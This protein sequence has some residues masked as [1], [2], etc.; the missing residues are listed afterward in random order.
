MP[1]GSSNTFPCLSLVS[2]FVSLYKLLAF[3]GAV[4]FSFFLTRTASVPT[5]AVVQSVLVPKLCTL[6]LC[7]LCTDMLCTVICFF[8][9][10]CLIFSL[11][12]APTCGSTITFLSVIYHAVDHNLVTS[13]LLYCIFWQ[14]FEPDTLCCYC[15]YDKRMVCFP[16]TYNLNES[17]L[18]LFQSSGMFLLLQS[19]LFSEFYVA[20]YCVL[21]FWHIFSIKG[22]IL[23]CLSSAWTENNVHCDIC[24]DGVWL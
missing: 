21:Y 16:L 5:V 11:G 12:H 9:D 24:T 18:F 6:S 8:L 23:C 19:V 13:V 1:P 2:S 7:T 22:N 3:K 20:R 4:L 17:V 15:Y 14:V 10:F